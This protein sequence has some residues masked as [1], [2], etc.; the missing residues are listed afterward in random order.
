MSNETQLYPYFAKYLALW[1]RDFGHDRSAHQP[2]F[3][4][5]LVQETLEAAFNNDD[6]T[7]VVKM[8]SCLEEQGTGIDNGGFYVH[9]N[10]DKPKGGPPTRSHH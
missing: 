4:T 6:N 3:T 10:F 2:S 7:V 9:R 1:T 5:I 8:I